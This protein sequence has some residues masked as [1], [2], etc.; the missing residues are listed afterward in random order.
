MQKPQKLDRTSIRWAARSTFCLPAKPPY[1]FDTR[2][3]VMEAHRTHAVP[4]VRDERS[5]IPM[6]LDSLIQRM[7]S[8]HA[9]DRPDSMASVILELDAIMESEFGNPEL[10]EF[11]G[12][13]VSDEQKGKISIRDREI[14]RLTIVY[15]AMI[16][17][18]PSTRLSSFFPLLMIALFTGAL[19]WSTQDTQRE[20]PERQKQKFEISST[21]M[22]PPH[23]DFTRN[24]QRVGLHS[25]RR[26]PCGC[27]RRKY[28][29][30]GFGERN[31][32]ATDF[33][34]Q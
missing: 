30:L 23:G 25:I 10:G 13:L 18:L 5:D 3:E 19:L 28:S 26:H 33:G 17:T 22:V 6:Q 12:T 29:D 8:K 7:M 1:Q 31:R 24:D 27:R 14:A 16:E 21:L 2:D 32:M 4:S 15:E 34:A 20:D 9:S 11:F